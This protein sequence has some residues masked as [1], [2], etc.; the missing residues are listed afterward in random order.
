[1]NNDIFRVE[2]TERNSFIL[3]ILNKLYAANWDA[4]NN[5]DRR[6]FPKNSP[7]AE[8]VK[9]IK[10]NAVH[11]GILVFIRIPADS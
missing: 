8:P 4:H 5:N 7:G 2:S 6:A 11:M 1:M 9:L 3:I 10:R